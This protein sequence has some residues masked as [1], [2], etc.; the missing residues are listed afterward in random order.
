MKD[1]H[2]WTQASSPPRATPVSLAYL[3]RPGTVTDFLGSLWGRAPQLFPRVL[4]KQAGVI[5]DL[6]GFESLL[7]SLHHGD[8]G[9]LHLARSGGR[10]SI[11]RSMLDEDGMLDLRQIRQ[12]FSAGETLYLTKAHRLSPT[13][14]A[15]CRA[16]E[17]DLVEHGVALRAPISAHVFLTP[18]Q[19]QGFAP[20]RDEHGSFVVQLS[21]TKQ[22]TIHAEGESLHLA[23]RRAGGLSRQSWESVERRTFILAPGDV[24]YVPEWYG[25]EARTSDEHSLH[26]TVRMFPLRWTDVLEEVQD[27]LPG[28]EEAVP[29]HAMEDPVGLARQLSLLLAPPGLENSLAK[30]LRRRSARLL[31]PRIVLPDDGLAQ[32]VAHDGIDEK[33]WLIRTAGTGCRVGADD[34]ATTLYFPGGSVQGPT[35]LRPVFDYVACTQVLRACD[36]PGAATSRM[37]ALDIVLKLVEG[38]VLRV[39]HPGELDDTSL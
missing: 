28:L 13:L 19:S 5:L 22:W 39:A 36:L 4:E 12:M 32:A 37:P 8:E 18:P 33:T 27:A 10:R 15:M 25:H 38:G 3:L 24:L 16:I 34:T 35:E 30:A 11:P 26:V 7:A 14:M 20:H 2:E 1:R 9:V 31:V 6:A 17:L 29:R 21:G 23:P